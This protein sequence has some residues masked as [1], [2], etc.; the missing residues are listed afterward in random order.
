VPSTS[1]IGAAVIL[2][3][4]VSGACFSTEPLSAERATA[5]RA[6]IQATLRRDAGTLATIASKRARLR[7]EDLQGRPVVC[8][9]AKTD[10]QFVSKAR[11]TCTLSYACGIEPWRP[12]Q[13][14]PVATPIVT[15]DLL[16]EHGTWLINGF[17]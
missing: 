14:S 15:L 1:G 9:L 13:G 5:E 7:R 6:A 2:A 11:A 8:A 3:A 17:P 10:I 12:E 16:K 4:T